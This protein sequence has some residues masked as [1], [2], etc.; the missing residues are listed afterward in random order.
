[1]Q[2]SLFPTVPLD[3]IWCIE[4]M[5]LDR[6][7]ESLNGMTIEALRA[8]PIESRLPME[9]KD[10]IAVINVDGPMTKRPSIFQAIFGGSSTQQ[11]QQAI[12]QAANNPSVKG[13]ML[14]V[15]SPGGSVDGISELSDAINHAKAS[16]PV[17]AQV[18]G[19]AASAAYWIASQA[20]KVFSN[21]M[22]KVGSI[23]ARM[24]LI[25]SSRLHENMGIKPV[26]IDTGKFKS[27]G[28]PGLAVTEEHKEHFQGIVDSHFKEFLGSVAKGRNMSEGAVKALADGRMFMA[29]DAV[30]LGLLDGIQ[31]FNE[32]FAALKQ[33]TAKGS[34][35]STGGIMSEQV[36]GAAE[37]T[38]V[39]AEPPKVEVPATPVA[40][41]EEGIRIQAAAPIDLDAIRQEAATAERKRVSEITALCQRHG[42]EGKLVNAL[43]SEGVSLDMA[44]GKVLDAL[45][46]KNIP[47]GDGNIETPKADENDPDAKYKA[48][49]AE[50]REFFANRG[51]EESDY[52]S[53]RRVDEGRDILL[54]FQRYERSKQHS[55]NNST[56]LAAK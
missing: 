54:P 21:R 17:Y 52:I 8:I 13:I 1:M 27:A 6:M 9:S 14:S 18:E 47:V 39:Q 37:E 15:D 50:N 38:Q 34:S 29:Q 23:G 45:A 46:V 41:L 30:G 19:T 5:A 42:I 51:W 7:T 56:S 28:S 44:R 36:K 35:V 43:I 12:H 48:E 11:I 49:Y 22:D 10:N 24:M 53:T 32:T 25:D 33:A 55:T 2:G 26:P 4:P 16:K 3:A 40:R 20:N 31:G